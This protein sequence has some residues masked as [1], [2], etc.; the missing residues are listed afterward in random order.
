[1][2]TSNRF[3]IAEKFT[4]R[5]GP[6]YKD[7]G[8]FSGEEF[9]EKELIPMVKR[10]EPVEI[11][12]D[13]TLWYGSSFLEEAF[14]GLIRETK[15]SADDFRRLFSFKSDEDRSYITEIMEYVAEADAEVRRG[16]VH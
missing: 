13:G 1:M 3:S 8:A 10:G 16:G 14:G 7:R 15:I 11:D 4:R 6:R 9:R 2:T 12:L 5:P